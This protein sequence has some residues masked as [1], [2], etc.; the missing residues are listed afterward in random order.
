[1]VEN[2]YNFFDV[3]DFYLV[4]NGHG[5]IFGKTGAGKTSMLHYIARKLV[6]K[7]ETIIVL[8]PH[9]DLSKNLL[10]E[11]TIFIS[12]LFLEINGKKYAVKMNLLDT[13]NDRSDEK[14]TAISESLKLL[15]S[16]DS[17]FSQGTWGPRLETIFSA[18]TPLVMKNV[19]NATISDLV[20]ALLKKEYINDHEFFKYLYGRNYFDYIQSTLNK[21]VPVV[22]NIYLKEFLCSRDVSFSFLGNELNGKLLAIYLA[23]PELGEFISRMAGSALLS[24]INNAV[25]FNKLKNVTLIIDEIKDFSPYLLPALFS[26]SRKFGLRIIIAAQYIKQ[27]NNDLYNSI[28]GNVS[29]I[30]TFRLSSED[31]F[32]LSKKFSI[33]N[34]KIERTILELPDRFALL[35]DDSIK[36]V[37]IPLMKKFNDFRIIERSYL[38]YGFEINFINDKILSIIYSLQERKKYTFFS[39][40]LNEYKNLYNGDFKSLESSLRILQLN[41]LIE[42][43]NNIFKITEKGL[44]NL[45]ENSYTEWE[46]PYHRY[47]ISRTANYF[48]SLGFDIKY[49]R[50]W[51]NEPDLIAKNKNHELYI[52]AEFADLK[53]PGKI[54]NHLIQWKN[55]KIIFVTFPEFGAKLFRI[56]CMPAIVNENG[57]IIFYKNNNVNVDYRDAGDYSTRVWILIVPEPGSIG[58]LSEFS[59]ILNLKES[60]NFEESKLFEINGKNI[61]KMFGED[62]YKIENGKIKTRLDYFKK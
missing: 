4:P 34:G 38:D 29:W 23:K 35:K 46:T 10:F 33:D 13:G 58:P 17:D 31:A 28:M 5:A 18:L 27:L 7:N 26:E 11:N 45:M 24:M 32:I 48:K 40:I 39:T 2:I 36:V 47:L 14:I 15:F 49:S 8:D 56:L 51:K 25:M 54:V 22:E 3:E 21:I 16:M 60:K 50:S 1:M 6:E 44:R 62:L 43:E 9:G 12:P 53:S 19:E 20:Q 42:K 52:E 59:P 30:S 61:L 57:K 37:K 41:D 55:K